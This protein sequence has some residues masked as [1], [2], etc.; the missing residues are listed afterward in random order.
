MV[1][2]NWLNN[3]ITKKRGGIMSILHREQRSLFLLSQRL[4]PRIGIICVLSLMSLVYSLAF[5]GCAQR[6][7]VSLDLIQATTKEQYPDVNGVI[8][9]DSTKVKVDE[10]GKADYTYHSLKKILSTYG[11]K[12]FGE[13]TFPYSASIGTVT[14]TLARVISPEGEIINV[15]KDDIKDVPFVELDFGAGSKILP[16]DLRM[17]KIIFPAL[18]I[19]ASTEYIVKLKTRKPLMKNKFTD[20]AIFEDEEPIADKVYT[21]ECPKD[22][23]IKYHIENGELEFSEEVKG[24]TKVYSWQAQNVPG[25]VKEPLMPSI[26]DVAT[27]VTIS[28]ITSWEEVSSWYYGLAAPMSVADSAIKAEVEELT[29]TLETEEQIVRSLFNFVSTEVRYLRTEAISK[30]EGIEPAAAEVTFERR[31]GVCRDKATLFVAMLKEVG[32]DAY[33]VFVDVSRH[34]DKE[35]P[36]CLFE[37]A[38]VAIKNTDGSYYYLD[39]TMEY[40]VDYYPPIEQNRWLLI[41]D[42]NGDSLRF[43]PY[44]EPENNYIKVENI[45]TLDEEGNLDAELSMTGYGF[46]DS[47]LRS[48][49]HIPPKQREMIFEQIVHAIS[50]DATL[51]EFFMSDPQ[52]LNQ[53]FTIEFSYYAPEYAIKKDNELHLISSGGMS[54]SFS[55]SLTPGGGGGSPWGLSERK[56]PIYFWTPIRTES[57]SELSLPKGYK[58]KGEL[59]N[60]EKD[61]GY[62]SV[63]VNRTVHKGILVEES[64]FFIKDPLIPP[65]AYFS[66]KTT[67]EELE[68]YQK[69]EIVLIKKK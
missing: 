67:M 42:E 52:D 62:L 8:L 30:E 44:I 23:K 55:S 47:Q 13:E 69:K 25:I 29:D 16:S 37:H 18:E 46:M 64:N 17:V 27:K 9:F 66:L 11:K 28:N 40:T 2:S 1:S 51:K 45:G 53:P 56:Y 21:L 34:T 39:P 58:V 50:P 36:T 24:K 63:A 26:M 43:V 3:L 7:S 5:F 10:S 12:K 60:F 54:S 65:E 4:I 22:M 48:F 38:I 31:W 68:K 32:K 20:I 35:V 41:C 59:E 19:G 61:I 33:I 14:V 15:P 49:R 57:I 6:V